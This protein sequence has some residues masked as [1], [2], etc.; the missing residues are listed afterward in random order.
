[1]ATGDVTATGL[2]PEV[3]DWLELLKD[4]VDRVKAWA[5]AAGWETR[6]T[7]RD[8]NEREGVR[9]EVPVLVLDRDEAEVSLVPVARKVPGADGLVDFYV[10]PDFEDVASLYREEGHWFFHYAFHADPI[11]THS[12]IET[13]RFPLDEASLD[14]VLNDI[15][16]HA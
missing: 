7:G 9:Y 16:A 15:A 4:L 10:M 12:L 3:D 13:E 5:E 6:L 2:P 14:R 8:V 1:M 11:E